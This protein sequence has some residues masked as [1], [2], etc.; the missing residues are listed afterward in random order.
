MQL[1]MG[2]RLAIDYEHAWIS[3]WTCMDLDKIIIIWGYI[4]CPEDTKLYL[5]SV[6]FELPTYHCAV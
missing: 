1:D 6:E 2:L 3:T 4:Q 5:P